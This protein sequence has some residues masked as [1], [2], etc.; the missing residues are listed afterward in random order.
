MSSFGPKEWL[1]YLSNMFERW[2]SGYDEKCKL[3]Q[4]LFH[5]KVSIT[6]FQSGGE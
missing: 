3:I 2:R 6:L 1:E 4:N 5:V